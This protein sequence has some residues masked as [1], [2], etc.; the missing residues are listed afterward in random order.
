MKKILILLI[1]LAEIFIIFDPLRVL[2]NNF[3]ARF[4]M[5]PFF[6]GIGWVSGFMGYM[7][8]DHRQI[9]NKKRIFNKIVY[10]IVIVFLNSL[11]VSIFVLFLLFDGEDIKIIYVLILSLLALLLGIFSTGIVFDDEKE[12]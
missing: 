3:N 6:I 10:W 12:N 5:Y 7:V 1:V 2:N 11:L 4:F 9:F 8:Y